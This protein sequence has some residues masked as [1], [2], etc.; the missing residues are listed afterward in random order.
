MSREVRELRITRAEVDG[1]LVDLLVRDGQ[2][3]DVRDS[4]AGPSVT[5][6]GS[7]PTAYVI[8]AEG[9]AVLPGLVDHHVHLLAL[10]ASL[11]SAPCGPP[12]VTDAA[13][14]AAALGRARVDESGWVRGVGYVETVAG[15]LDRGGLE[16]LRPGVPVRVQHRSGAMWMLNE[17]ATRV[18][19]LD[20]ADHP[21]VERDRAGRATGRLFRADDWLRERVASAPP[22]LHQVGQIL[23]GL[24][25]TAVT[26]ATP[27]LGPAGIELLRAAVESGDLA[28]EVTLLG[29]A[30][31]AD[32]ATTAGLGRLRRGP[33]KIVLADSGL[34]DIDDLVARIRASH[35]VG[36]AIAVHC[37]TLEAIHLLVAALSEAGTIPGDRVEHAAIV[38]APLLPVL[39]RLGL[40]VVT[41]PG[42]IADRGDDY[43]RD[44][45]EAE[46][47]NLYRCAT[48]VA[49]GV[50]LALSSDAP[51]G[52]LD[53]W[54]VMRAATRR[55]TP[56]G[57][58]L[59]PGEVMRP[60]Q[61][62]MA[63]LADPADPGGVPRRVVV[64][65]PADLAVLDAPLP[66]VLADPHGDR[67]RHVVRRGR[68]VWPPQPGSDS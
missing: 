50:P 18:V 22:S 31:D 51:Y 58:V 5:D 48:L 38:P 32:L 25:I 21:G 3:A 62:L 60:Q 17:T 9:G 65:A 42:F 57:Q 1:R 47:D 63:L 55:R 37:V 12:A 19:G 40:R 23:L 27:D 34:P 15:A 56:S 45:P 59:G 6:S 35:A 67:V 49:A 10:A 16:Q 26:D 30:D 29:A 11:R 20:A 43:A 36:R 46:H 2:V 39:S 53:P 14:L 28:V 13:S 4:V 33:R 52:P 24:G 54:F 66:E 68:P 44:V 61:A 8:D 41:Q 64:G 7:R